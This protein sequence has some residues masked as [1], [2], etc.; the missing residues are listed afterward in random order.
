[1]GDI[2]GGLFGGGDDAADASR[3]ASAAQLEFQREALE[4]LKGA[5]ELPMEIRDQFLPGLAEF[6]ELPNFGYMD[7]GK[8]IN[9]AM[10]SPLYKQLMGTRKA[11]EQTIL[12]NASATGG[13]RSG[14]AQGALT[15]YGSQLKS[16]ALLQAY[17]AQLGLLDK[18]V[19]G[20]QKLGG[21]NT[22]ENG[23]ANMLMNMGQTT[24]Q[25]IIGA[26]QSEQAGNQ[27]A[28]DNI[29]GIAT[30]A[31]MFSDIRMKQNIRHVGKRGRWNWYTWDWK[32]EVRKLL[33]FPASSEGV[34]AHEVYE[35]MPEA[36]GQIGGF[37]HVNYHMLEAS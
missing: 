3:E 12:R 17:Q 19:A 22:N 33:G 8:L 18:T 11:G 29:L 24:G 10:R 26:A 36:V 23:I 32:P 4:Y 35:E 28:I 20:A 21:I 37:L 2:I 13:L 25:G 9:R 7:Q 31:A 5:N 16:N 1:M 6:F 15:D 27:Q 30:A 34:L 14:N